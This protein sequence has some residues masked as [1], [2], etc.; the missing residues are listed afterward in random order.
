MNAIRGNT[1]PRAWQEIFAQ[2]TPKQRRWAF[3]AVKM[4]EHKKN[5][6]DIGKRHRI[7]PWYVGACAQGKPGYN[8][9]PPVIAALEKDLDID[10]S[11][12]LEP[13]E[14]GKVRWTASKKGKPKEEAI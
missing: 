3:I 7:T 5:F 14:A 13:L 1:D 2:F 6:T 8:L 10:L 12:F 9:G 4:A 11:P